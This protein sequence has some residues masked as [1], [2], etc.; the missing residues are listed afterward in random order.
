MPLFSSGN[1]PV[2]PPTP[3]SLAAA[4]DAPQGPR[5]FSRAAA[6]TYRTAPHPSDSTDGVFE[7]LLMLAADRLDPNGEA[8]K[9]NSSSGASRSKKGSWLGRAWRHIMDYATN[10]LLK[11]RQADFLNAFS[12]QLEVNSAE[13][14]STVMVSC[15]CFIVSGGKLHF[16]SL[17]ATNCG[18]YFCSCAPEA[19]PAAAAAAESDAGATSSADHRGADDE[20]EYIKERILFTD[21][22]SLLPSIFLEQDGTA[23]P[24]IQGIPNG[25]V[26]PTALQ[27]FTVQLSTVLQF[28]NLHNVAVKRPKRSAAEA[29]KNGAGAVQEA[30]CIDVVQKHEFNLVCELPPS[31][32]TLKFCALLW[33]LWAQRLHDLGRPLEHPAVHYAEPH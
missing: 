2:V 30:P 16:G 19:A 23:T 7:A 5:D 4:K 17:F 10:N 20:V 12:R 14:S 29:E 13:E 33:R 22:A 18:L 1:T 11:M 32:D 26:A 9:E 15:Q 8:M 31:L 6:L 25:V 21:V 27:V 28:L 3:T 24:F